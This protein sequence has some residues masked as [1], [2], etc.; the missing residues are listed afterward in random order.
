MFFA[1]PLEIIDLLED[2]LDDEGNVIG[3]KIS[4]NATHDQIEMFLKYQ[5]ECRK[6][7]KKDKN[8]FKIKHS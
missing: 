1:P 5:K 4:K 7:E 8:Q 2:V 3:E 6:M